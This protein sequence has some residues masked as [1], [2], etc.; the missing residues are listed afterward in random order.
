MCDCPTIKLE[1]GLL[2]APRLYRATGSAYFFDPAATRPTLQLYV[3]AG[4]GPG[5]KEKI[6]GHSTRRV[7]ALV[8]RIEV[9]GLHNGWLYYRSHTH[10][11]N[12]LT[13]WRDHVIGM[14]GK[15]DNRSS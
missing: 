8:R 10:T 7:G 9:T 6:A 2:P 1:V 5:Q 15:R 13:K 14:E 11:H 12:R 4:I 3:V